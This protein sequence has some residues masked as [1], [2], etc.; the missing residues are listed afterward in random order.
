MKGKILKF[1]SLM[2]IITTA[3]LG[4]LST[5]LDAATS[6]GSSSSQ[7]VQV[8]VHH[9]VLPRQLQEAQHHLVHQ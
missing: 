1:I 4:M 8:V 5:E 6:G 9:Q 3:S 2:I 7:V